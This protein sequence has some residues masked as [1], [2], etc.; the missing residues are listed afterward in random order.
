MR[1]CKIIIA[2]KYLQKSCTYKICG[3]ALGLR[4]MAL[5]ANTKNDEWIMI[6]TNATTVER[7]V[8]YRLLNRHN[9]IIYTPET[10]ANWH[11]LRHK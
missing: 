3:G 4:A 10:K 5:S 1:I 8:Q 2:R 7:G 6:V 9:Q 11:L